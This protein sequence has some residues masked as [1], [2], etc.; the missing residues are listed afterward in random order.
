MVFFILR[1]EVCNSLEKWWIFQSYFF[2]KYYSNLKNS[3]QTSRSNTDYIQAHSYITVHS[4]KYITRDLYLKGNSKKKKST[5]LIILEGRQ[6]ELLVS[7]LNLSAL[8]TEILI[9]KTD[10]MIMWDFFSFKMLSLLLSLFLCCAQ[11]LSF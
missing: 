10:W 11:D 5:D 3:S 9:R 7:S 2:V 8:G 4:G 1:S 6:W